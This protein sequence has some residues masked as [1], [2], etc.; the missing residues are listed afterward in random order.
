MRT[1]RGAFYSPRLVNYVKRQG[2][3]VNYCPDNNIP[4]LHS[5][6]S[7]TQETLSNFGSALRESTAPAQEETERAAEVRACDDL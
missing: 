7:S 3:S 4:F 2:A 5:N 6:K 1:I